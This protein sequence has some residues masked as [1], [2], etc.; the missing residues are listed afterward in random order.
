MYEVLELGAEMKQ[1]QSLEGSSALECLVLRLQSTSRRRER[2]GAV[3]K[4]QTAASASASVG[5]AVEG[6]ALTPL[7]SPPSKEMG[8][9]VLQVLTS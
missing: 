6:T 1:E 8:S 5:S 7:G 9:R 3:R 2:S 4:E